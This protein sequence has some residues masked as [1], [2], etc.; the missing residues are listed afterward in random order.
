R[1]GEPSLPAVTRWSAAQAF[2]GA[3]LLDVELETG[4]QHQ[5]RIHL[6]HIGLP[7]L[8]DAVYGREQRGPL[9]VARQMLHARTLAF[10]HPLTGSRVQA[11]APLPEDMRR[12]LAGL[13]RQG[14]PRAPSSAPAPG[15][16]PSGSARRA[17]RRR[18]P[19]RA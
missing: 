17:P 7:I 1:E 5:I 13:R 19:R 16:R 3:A 12:V 2:R 15:P 9:E 10:V 8:G 11:E 6:A 14:K 18:S 4:R